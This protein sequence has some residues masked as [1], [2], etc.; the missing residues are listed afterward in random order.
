MY[1]PLI[2]AIEL[3]E[4]DNATSLTKKYLS[5][6]VPVVDLI[7][8]CRIGVQMVG[9]RYQEGEYYLSDLVMSEFILKEI[10]E[11]VEPHLPA[12]EDADGAPGDSPEIVIGTIEGDIHDLGKNIVIYLLRASGYKVLDLGVDVPKEKFVEAVKGG[13]RIIGICFLMTSC[14]AVVKELIDILE[15]ENLR[16]QVTVIIGGYAA[17]DQTCAYVGA[18]Y[19][20]TN[21]TN[22]IPLFDSV[23]GVKRPDLGLGKR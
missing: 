18:D 21:T 19:S 4:I 13:T 5:E 23:L 7:E 10:T 6:N 22:I 12:A 20:A 17:D 8:S 14:T 1:E 11:L 15:R 2:R 16:H 9:K 3:L